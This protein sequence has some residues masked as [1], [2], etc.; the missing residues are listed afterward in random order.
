MWLAKTDLIDFLDPE[1]SPQEPVSVAKWGVAFS[2]LEWAMTP[3]P[4]LYPERY[5]VEMF[6]RPELLGDIHMPE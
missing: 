6:P 1:V 2:R 3:V 4:N 5:E